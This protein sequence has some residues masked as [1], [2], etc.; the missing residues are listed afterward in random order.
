MYAKKSG[1]E[2][3]VFSGLSRLM[4]EDPTIRVEKNVETTESLLSG[5]GEMHLEVI[6]KKLS[7]KFGAECVL[8]DPKIPY[9]ETIR[10]TLDC[11]GRHK[12]QT[13]GHGQF[14]DV[15]MRFEPGDTEELQ[16]CVEDR[17]RRCTQEL[18]P[19]CG[20]GHER[21]RGSRRTGGLSRGV[22]EGY[23]V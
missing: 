15:W 10:K 17:G 9:R 8:Q 12:K 20:K 21:G 22:P 19:R 1:E 16:F 4:E 3:K 7:S 23:P 5:L 13:G 6:T 2:D 11:E 18:L 14:G